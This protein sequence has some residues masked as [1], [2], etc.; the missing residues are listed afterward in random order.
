MSTVQ[1]HSPPDE[2]SRAR[3]ERPEMFGHLFMGPDQ[4]SPL[5]QREAERRERARRT[6][7]GRTN[8]WKREQ[9]PSS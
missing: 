5:E 2:P 1:D 3:A 4:R 8:W 9:A 6:G 7:K